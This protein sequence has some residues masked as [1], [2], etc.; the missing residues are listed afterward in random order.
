MAAID[1]AQLR[2]AMTVGTQSYPC[3][4][5]KSATNLVH[6]VYRS[7]IG[8]ILSNGINGLDVTHENCISLPAVAGY[9]LFS[10]ELPKWWRADL[11]S[12]LTATNLVAWRQTSFR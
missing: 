1:C 7:Y 4:A 3:R 5:G 12:L 6:G 8:H 10:A 11:R 9:S 2:Q